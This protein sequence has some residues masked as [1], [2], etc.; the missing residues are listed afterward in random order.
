MTRT[1]ADQG[2]LPVVLVVDHDPAARGSVRAGLEARQLAVVEAASARQACALLGE[3]LTAAVVGG[4]LDD[5]ESAD[6]AGPS[7][8]RPGAW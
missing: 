2:C 4:G 3:P 7:R 1:V 6:L 5:G 8:R